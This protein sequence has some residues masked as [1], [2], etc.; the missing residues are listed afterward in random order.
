MNVRFAWADPVTNES[1]ISVWMS[2][3]SPQRTRDLLMPVPRV[4]KLP[5]LQNPKRNEM[6]KRQA[7]Y[8]ECFILKPLCEY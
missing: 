6:M 3:E 7:R 4:Q 1:K 2:P 8:A 5:A